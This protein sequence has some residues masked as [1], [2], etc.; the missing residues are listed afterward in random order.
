V[1]WKESI[2]FDFSHNKMAVHI[3]D[4]EA[5]QFLNALF[6]DDNQLEISYIKQQARSASIKMADV[7]AG[8][9]SL[10]LELVRLADKSWAW[11]MPS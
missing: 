8:A 10:N 7:E 11:R 1:I 2:N 9:K 3:L 6:E 4:N 5:V